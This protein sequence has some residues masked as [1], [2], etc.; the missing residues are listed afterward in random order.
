[1]KQTDIAS[2]ETRSNRRVFPLQKKLMNPKTK[3]AIW[4]GVF[5]ALLLVP[6]LVAVTF[7]KLVYVSAF[8]FLNFRTIVR[9]SGILVALFVVVGS[10]PALALLVVI[11]LTALGKIPLY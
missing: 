1:M 7:G 5:N 10:L 8:P 9:D 6:M 4:H 2:F 3:T 11:G